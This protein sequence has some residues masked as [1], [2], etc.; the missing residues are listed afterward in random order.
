MNV[1]EA[2][3]SRFSVRA[4]LDQP[5]RKPIVE[6]ILEKARRAPSGGNLQPWFVHVL[7]G[8]PLEELKTVICERLPD[9]PTGEGAEYNVYPPKLKEP[10]RSRR[11][12]CGEDLYASINV[13]RE[14]KPARLKQYANSFR[15]FGAPVALFFSIDRSMEIAQYVDLGLFLQ[16]IMLL[17]REE[18]LHT[19]SQESWSGWYEAVSEF[20]SLPDERM[21]FCG[22]AMGYI[23]DSHPI[24]SWRTE[25]ALIDEFV[26]WRGFHESSDPLV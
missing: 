17:A 10:Y 14:D 13:A 11:Y 24:N 6:S 15:F 8:E 19:C 16:S 23:D 9:H 2:I 3:A 5:V 1:S 21:L 18:G 25:R 7:N 4:F 22:M 26:T 12:K 20:L